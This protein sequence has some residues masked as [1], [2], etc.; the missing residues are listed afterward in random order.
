MA[1]EDWRLQ[2]GMFPEIGCCSS[3]VTSD[4]VYLAGAAIM[5]I[6]CQLGGAGRIRHAPE[7]IRPAME[8]GIPSIFTKRWPASIIT[9]S[10]SGS[11]TGRWKRGL[12]LLYLI[13]D[14]TTVSK[15]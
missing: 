7:L 2:L 4:S 8:V 6:N 13:R 14:K 15:L 9:M 1:F 12:L 10:S 3:G 11:L 5:L